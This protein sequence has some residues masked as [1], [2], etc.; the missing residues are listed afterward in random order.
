M[1]VGG[2]LLAAGGGR[3]LGGV[4]LVVHAAMALL[5]SG[6]VDR[7]IVVAGQGDDDIRRVLHV[8][9][10]GVAPVVVDGA[11]SPHAS[12]HRGLA[13]LDSGIRTVVLHDALRPL[14]P[15]QVVTRVVEAVRGGADLAVPVLEVTETVKELDAAGR[16]ARTVPR[17]TL[18]RVQAPQAAR[19]STADA[20]HRA[21]PADADGPAWLGGGRVRAVAVAGSDDAFR[22]AGPQD[23]AV[24]EALLATRSGYS[25][26]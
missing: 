12:L 11:A 13:A 19:R 25:T 21:C 14:A 15:P 18:V 26:R 24:A 6:L 17:E 2:V 9:L 3:L 5:G 23:L 20:A 7:L 1:S 4:P 22:L 8:R 16:V 10:P